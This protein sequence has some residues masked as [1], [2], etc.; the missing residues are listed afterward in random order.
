MEAV[1]FSETA[2]HHNLCNDAALL[3]TK[4]FVLTTAA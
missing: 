2:V 1:G 3:P 4:P